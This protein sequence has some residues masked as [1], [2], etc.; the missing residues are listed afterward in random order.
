MTDEQKHAVR[1]WLEGTCLGEDAAIERFDLDCDTDE[2]TDAMLDVNLER[3]KG[4]DWW[5]ECC[6]LDDD[7]YCNNCA[8]DDEMDYSYRGTL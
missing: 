8:N 6:M 7:G 3:C 2:V 1:A 4:C 5:M